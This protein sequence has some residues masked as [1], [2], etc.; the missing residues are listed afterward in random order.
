VAANTIVVRNPR[1]LEP[2]L[3]QL[4]TGKY[5]SLRDY[6]HLEARLR[7]RIP[8]HEAALALQALIRR[9]NFEPEARVK[10]YTALAA[11]FREVVPFPPEAVEGIADEQYV[12]NVVEVLFRP[13]ERGAEA[14]KAART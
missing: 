14:I 6:P 10:I 2:D 11:H 4:G 12:R 8:P 13:R 9:E 3:D 1:I 5:N 7:Q